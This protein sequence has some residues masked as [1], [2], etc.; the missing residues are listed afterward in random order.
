MKRAETIGEALGIEGDAFSAGTGDEAAADF[1]LDSTTYLV[2]SQPFASAEPAA[3]PRP[4][5]VASAS[6]ECSS[7]RLKITK[8]RWK[9]PWPIAAR[10]AAYPRPI[11]SSGKKNS[12][13]SFAATQSISLL[14]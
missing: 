1:C 7:G 6:S 14:P 10:Q 9:S 12:G 5:V 13:S 4:G 3:W 11:A 8:A 2:L